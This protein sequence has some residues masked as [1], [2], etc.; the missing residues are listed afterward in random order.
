M[1]GVTKYVLI[2]A[3]GT[4]DISFV[5]VFF[6]LKKKNSQIGHVMPESLYN[7]RNNLWKNYGLLQ[8]ILAY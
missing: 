2:D 8:R 7:Q 1:N 4:R 6:K 3:G 5:F